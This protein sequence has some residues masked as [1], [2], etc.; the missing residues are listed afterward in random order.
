M[1]LRLH[2]LRSAPQPH[3]NSSGLAPMAIG[4]R[5]RG[6]AGLMT[7]RGEFMTA[8]A[9][10]SAGEWTLSSGVEVTAY[11][12]L[13]EAPAATVRSTV[14]MWPVPLRF[15]MGSVLTAP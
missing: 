4:L 10:A 15:T 14:M 6:A 13:E 1:A 2:S 9:A 5:Q 11:P 3:R 12:R 7:V 8:T